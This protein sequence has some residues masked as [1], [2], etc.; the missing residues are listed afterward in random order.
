LPRKRVAPVFALVN[1]TDVGGAFR[2][3]RLRRGA[4]QSDIAAAARVARS[5]ISDIER[6]H[7][8]E[9]TLPHLR[10]VAGVL[11]V[12]L[13]IVP[14]WRGGEL[15]R[16]LSSR[17][18]A[19]HEAFARRVDPLAGWQFSP[20]VS[21]SFFG[22]RGVVD[23]LGW[24]ETSRSLLIVELKSEIVDVG[25]LLGTLDRK[26]RLG[27]RIAAERGLA[28]PASVSAW[29]VLREDRTN[30]RHAAGLRTLLRAAFPLD[31]QAMS[32]W[33]REPSGAVAALSFMSC[34]ALGDGARP[35]GAVYRLRRRR[36]AQ[37]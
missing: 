24:H 32:A 25:E 13:D 8:D 35:P 14:R 20:E 22:E 1:D 11:E 19:M 15:P 18:A 33:L 3:I 28:A 26:R 23:Q 34:V 5:V 6:G 37:P 30:R 7:L 9:V 17:H 12:R 10:R 31:G 21:F 36:S 27:A 16:L 2:E 4:R 29:I